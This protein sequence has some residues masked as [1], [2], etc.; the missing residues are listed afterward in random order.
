MAITSNDD[1][2]DFR[3][4]DHTAGAGDTDA[5]PGPVSRAAGRADDAPLGGAE[6]VPVAGVWVLCRRRS[7]GEVE[8]VRAF[9]DEA[10]ACADLELAASV[11]GDE[12]WVSAVPLIE[13]ATDGSGRSGMSRVQA[14]ALSWLAQ[15]AEAEASVPLEDPVVVSPRHVRG[16]VSV[17][18]HEW[19]EMEERGWVRDGLIT[20][21]GAAR[22]GRSGSALTAR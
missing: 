22:I 21:E 12:F 11:S 6:D 4:A 14:L 7:D 1:V 16:F 3:D 5:I 10:R 13:S 2:A 18:S 19:R 8:T 15:G 17:P 20:P 9:D